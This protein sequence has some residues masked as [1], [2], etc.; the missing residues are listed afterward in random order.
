MAM[1]KDTIVGIVG[2]VILVGAMVGVFW[3][4]GTQASALGAERFAVNFPNQAGSF[5]EVKGSTLEGQSTTQTISV[6]RANL[7]SLEFSLAWTDDEAGTAADQF[8]LTVES[9]DGSISRSKGPATSP[10][11]VAIDSATLGQAAPEPKT[12]NGRNEADA[13]SRV[14][15]AHTGTAGNG[16]W[17]V[18][19]EMSQAGKGTCAPQPVGCPAGQGD[20][21]NSWTLKVAYTAYQAQLL[22]DDGQV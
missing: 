21:G 10:I 22:A 17:T 4:E 20:T 2:A 14:A 5:P 9:P 16:N 11:S 1:N 18:T 15:A 3:Y 7:T 12:E 6:D 8:I 13:A 19:I